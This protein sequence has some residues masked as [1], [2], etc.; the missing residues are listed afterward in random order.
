MSTLNIYKSSA[1]SGKTHTLTLNYLSLLL[2]SEK[3]YR[4]ILAVT[5][6]NK[7]AAEMK[8]RILNSLYLLYTKDEK[9]DKLF[10]QLEGL[11]SLTKEQ[12]HKRSGDILLQILNDYSLFRVETIDK[13]FQWIIRNFARET[14]LQAGYNLELNDK[15]IL[16]EA[17]DLLMYSL[18]EDENLKK[19]LLRFAEEKIAEGKDWNFMKDLQNLGSEIFR[20]RY[21]DISGGYK[22]A[23]EDKKKLPEYLKSLN[24]VISSF[25]DHMSS[26]GKKALDYI[27]EYKL[28]IS[29]FAHKEKGVAGYFVKIAHKHDFDPKSRARNV[30]AGKESWTVAKA[31]NI[32]IVERLVNK[33]LKKL[34][35]DA[36][37]YFDKN[38]SSYLT[39]KLIIRN[40][41]SFGV[42]TDIY[43]KV[44]EISAEKNIFLLSDAAVFLKRLIAGNDAPFIFEKAGNYY[45]NFMLDEFQDTS[46]YQWNNFQPLILNG[47]ANDDDSL[48]VGDVK[49]S[50]YRWRNSN[51]EILASQA[52]QSFPGFEAKVT[53]LDT[54]WRSNKVIVAFNNSMFNLINKGLGRLV[55]SDCNTSKINPEFEEKWKKT[56]NDIYS[57]AAQIVPEQD[58]PDKG[59][60]E[61]SFYNETADEYLK[62]LETI[63]PELILDIQSRA[64]NPGDIAILVRTG[65]QG[66]AVAS[67]LMDYASRTKD[68]Y[69][70]NIIS[71]DS[72]YIENHSSVRFLVALLKYL[73]NPGDILNIAFIRHEYIGYLM[74]DEYNGDEHSVFGSCNEGL[75]R[76]LSDPID[77][78]LDN[79]DRI[80]HL[81]LYEL[82]E[83]LISIFRLHQE[84]LNIAYLQAF[85]DLVLDFVN[86]ENSDISAFIDWWDKFG[87]AQTLN[88]PEAQDAIQIITIFKAKGLE[89]P[90][91][92]VPFC[93]WSMDVEKPGS[94]YLW[95]NSSEKP[96]DSM[97]YVPVIY[98]KDLLNTEFKGYYLNERFHNYIDNINLLYVALTRP[99]SEL[100]VMANHSDKSAVSGFI[101]SV[102]KDK[103]K[104]I[105][106]KEGYPYVDINITVENDI[107]KIIAGKKDDTAFSERHITPEFL[108]E[109]PVNKNRSKLILNTGSAWLEAAE[110]STELNI[111]YG[112]VMHEIFS[113]IN[114]IQD[115]ESAVNKVL[116]A[117]KISG[118]EAAELSLTLNNELQ[119]ENV[120]HWFDGSW[121]VKKEREL[122]ISGNK[123][124]RPDRVMQKNGLTVVL[125]YKFGKNIEEKHNKQVRYYMNAIR[126][127]DH[128]EVKGYLW[129]FTL[130]EIRE[131]I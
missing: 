26:L 29:D 66:R 50:I 65:K 17:L 25:E 6:T 86:E 93:E 102:V 94:T 106:K 63:L 18:D 36:I 15:R 56:I 22:K 31:D 116:R 105:E 67:I 117:G 126:K 30:L 97:E 32:L 131:V 112:T 16:I 129:Y 79:Y 76:G 109:Y 69:R 108:Q 61:F 64:Y 58:M 10:S 47:L 115:I 46:A 96:F 28:D 70:F 91:V 71:N 41:F 122:C 40:I 103:D 73:V 48:L 87:E 35:G 75:T 59:Y 60:V 68:S 52:E 99:M 90:V 74:S 114:T 80:R 82:L 77:V 20:E 7:A 78:F 130:G 11:T 34:L 110:S 124:L 42:L 2:K 45:S 128:S 89:F 88:V 49:Q 113:S 92:I 72:L 39:A 118:K 14:G 95:C 9:V 5:F 127:S 1:G 111:G 44:R 4:S 13:F 54:N 57:G 8:D 62:K 12:I 51:W 37:E 33:H 27:E 55:E 83:E 3:A 24:V 101:Y 121:E 119:K 104:V 98:K 123:I 53:P 125:D 19:W 23:V 84:P 21:Q 85:Q 120:R 43:L 100:Y 38:I 107:E 81:P